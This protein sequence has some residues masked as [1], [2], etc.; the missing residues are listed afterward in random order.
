[1][2]RKNRFTLLSTALLLAV[3]ASVA[4]DEPTDETILD[5]VQVTANRYSQSEQQAIASVTVLERADIEQSAA[6]DLFSL[7]QH[8]G[9]V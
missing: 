8:P 4:A 6:P 7:L 2:M 5:T 9:P 3:S 1:M